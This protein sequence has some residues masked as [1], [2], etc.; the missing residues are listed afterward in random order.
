M[1]RLTGNGSYRLGETKE[2]SRFLTL[3]SYGDN[4]TYAWEWIDGIQFRLTDKEPV[5]T[6]YTLAAGKYRLYEVRDEPGLANQLHLELSAGDGIWQGYL[7][8]EG[9]PVDQ[10]AKKV[11]PIDEAITKSFTSV[12]FPVR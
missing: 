7:L 5:D 1:I 12:H 8:P 6:G 9:L 4:C 2:A 10:N 11:L 3:D